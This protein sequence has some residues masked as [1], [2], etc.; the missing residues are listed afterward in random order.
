MSEAV[1]IAVE[2]LERALNDGEHNCDIHIEDVGD[3]KEV[4][5]YVDSEC[6]EAEPTAV[7]HIVPLST[8]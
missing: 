1:K 8:E 2:N 5:F 3:M 7:L 4:S 6:D